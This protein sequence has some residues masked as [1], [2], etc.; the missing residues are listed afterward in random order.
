VQVVTD[1]IEEL[2]AKL[3][4]A[5]GLGDHM[6]NALEHGLVGFR[7][8]RAWGRFRSELKGEKDD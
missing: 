6:A 8:H 1:R 4:K 5:L 7:G 2:E 3:A